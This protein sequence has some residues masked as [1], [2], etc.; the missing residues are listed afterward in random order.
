M[1]IIRFMWDNLFDAATTTR[2]ASSEATD[3]EVANIVNRW[4]TRRWRS[5]GVAAEWVKTDLGSPQEIKSLIIKNHQFTN[6]ATITIQANTIDDWAAP[7]LDTV[8]PW[9]TDRIIKWWTAGETY[10]WW[11]VLIADAANPAGYVAIGRI[12]LGSYF[13]PQINFTRQYKKRL[14]DPSIKMYSTGGQ[15]SA[16]SKLHYREWA[17]DFEI[18][19]APDNVTFEEVF[20][21]VGQSK[22]YFICQDAD[23][24]WKTLYYVENLSDWDIQHIS[25]DTYFGMGLAVE[26]MR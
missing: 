21:G 20:A 8:L 11:R 2:T 4:H 22:P 19:E 26:E 7:P 10:R 15:I 12:F 3:Y 5:T 6:A 23:D 24:E 17:Y 13:T 16:G 14:V 18:I 9:T 25:M 1:K